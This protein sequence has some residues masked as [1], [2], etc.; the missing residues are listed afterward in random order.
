MCP[1]AQSDAD[2]DASITTAFPLQVTT[3]RAAHNRKLVWPC[4]GDPVA[5]LEG[6]STST[7]IKLAD[8][9]EYAAKLGVRVPDD[10]NIRQKVIT[11]QL[12]SQICSQHV[13]CLG[14]QICFVCM[15][16]SVEDQH[17]FLIDC[18][19]YSHMIQQYSHLLRQASPSVAAFLAT[20]QPNV[21]GS[22]FETCFAQ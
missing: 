20:D 12:N 13:P 2:A 3:K 11:G 17:H 8:T 21:V 1:A 6:C 15:S 5:G 19:T 9:H 10:V 22:F 7:C 18:P 16:G 14:F 4:L